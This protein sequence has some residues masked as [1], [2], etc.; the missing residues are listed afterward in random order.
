MPLRGPSDVG[1]PD[2]RR[3]SDLQVTDGVRPEGDGVRGSPAPPKR[4]ARTSGLAAVP[5]PVE[6]GAS[7]TPTRD[8]LAPPADVS[9]L[10][11]LGDERLVHLQADVPDVVLQRVKLVSFE[12][13]ADHPHLRRHQ[14]ILG[15][16]VWA[17]VDHADQEKLDAL[18]ELV[19]RYAAGA[20]HGLPEVRRLSG[21]MPASLKRRMEGAVLAI[22]G[23]QRD[24]SAK[25]V[26][27]ALVWRYVVSGGEDPARF[28][29]LVDALGGYQQELSQRSLKAPVA[30]VRP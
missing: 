6:R 11:L 15:A 25:S 4:T 1:V 3:F 7:P 28:R 17:H 27:A 19:D 24:V 29:G 18:A 30:S 8:H 2:V 22:D 14:L 10:Q 20:W 5:W 16:L 21:R 26:V 9:R 13:A 23:S 12:L